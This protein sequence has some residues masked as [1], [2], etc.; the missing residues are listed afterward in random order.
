PVLAWHARHRRAFLDEIDR[1]FAA[2]HL[3][4]DGSF[5]R[6]M[7]QAT[8]PGDWRNGR[9]VASV[10]IEKYV[11][12]LEYAQAFAAIEDRDPYR[13]FA[14]RLRYLS[15]HR[16]PALSAARGYAEAARRRFLARTEP[17]S[18][19]P[20][21]A[22]VREACGAIDVA[23]PAA[24]RRAGDRIDALAAGARYLASPFAS[25]EQD[26]GMLRACR[27]EAGK[28]RDRFVEAAAT[29]LRRVPD[30]SAV[31]AAVAR[32]VACAIERADQFERTV[33]SAADLLRRAREVPADGPVQARLD[34]YAQLA[35]E[36]R[37]SGAA[38]EL[39]AG[40]LSVPVGRQIA[41]E[42]EKFSLA[43]ARGLAALR[44]L[45]AA[46][47]GSRT[48]PVPTSTWSMRRRYRELQAARERGETAGR[49]ERQDWL[50][51]AR[52]HAFLVAVGALPVTT[53]GEPVA[54]LQDRFLRSQ[55]AGRARLSTAFGLR[56]SGLADVRRNRKVGEQVRL[57]EVDGA[58]VWRRAD[59]GGTPVDLDRYQ[60]DRDGWRRYREL[61][62]KLDDADAD[63]KA[64]KASE[65]ASREELVE[66]DRR[67][68]A[69]SKELTESMKR[70]EVDPGVARGRLAELKRES[71]AIGRVIRNFNR[72]VKHINEASDRYNA[73]VGPHNELLASL[74]KQEA[75]AYEQ[76]LMPACVEF[77]EGRIA[78]AWS[79]EEARARRW[80]LGLVDDV[81]FDA[82]IPVPHPQALATRVRDVSDP[83]IAAEDILA[84]LRRRRDDQRL[85]QGATMAEHLEA[86]RGAVVAYGRRYGVDELFERVLSSDVVPVADRASVVPFFGEERRRDALQRLL[87]GK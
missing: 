2:Q 42:A 71:A 21:V 10:A 28:L 49:D 51:E 87:D 63:L 70:G 52:A 6:S 15:S 50:T 41:Q 26:L 45:E 8:K 47:L 33:A 62:A 19:D 7:R 34:A 54:D 12:V 14:G 66:R 57:V 40:E 30:A 4:E 61:R 68:A 22:A 27:I 83:A 58:I 24:F 72:R 65:G 86:L 48:A 9:P 74:L 55:L 46:T 38:W 43:G 32:A 36:A 81:G 82:R 25:V 35:T 84:S 5:H 13:E 20:F 37:E 39:V 16:A 31:D 73:M 56:L 53:E 44:Y 78:A 60:I 64:A 67:V 77:A 3:P 23:S 79:G 75:T 85:W 80:I 18:P 1:A 76:L 11:A 59:A 17:V 69:R 29:R